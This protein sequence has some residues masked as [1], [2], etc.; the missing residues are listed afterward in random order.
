MAARPDMVAQFAR[1]LRSHYAEQGIDVQ[2]RATVVASLN[3]RPEAPLVDPDVDL[4]RVPAFDLARD[5][6]EPHPGG[7]PRS[8]SGSGDS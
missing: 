6:I 8:G 7:P 1:Y 2:V 4:S 3:G 5:W